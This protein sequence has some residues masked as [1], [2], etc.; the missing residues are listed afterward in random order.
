MRSKAL[1][2]VT[3]RV[4]AR[5]LG[6]RRELVDVGARLA[7]LVPPPLGGRKRRWQRRSRRRRRRATLAPR[8]IAREIARDIKNQP[9]SR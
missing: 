4:H 6:V 8:E 2:H 9:G 3:P 7:T 1:G 5:V